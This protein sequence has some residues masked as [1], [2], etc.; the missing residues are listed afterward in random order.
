MATTYS[1]IHPIALGLSFAIIAGVATLLMGLLAHA[2]FN[3]KPL[4]S[5]LG[6]MYITYNPSLMNSA[7]GALIAA[8]N[9]LIGGYIAA[10]I[11]NLLCDY[12]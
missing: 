1:K 9:G 7:I 2:V 11:Y 12:I 4:V 8:V 3:G 5:M 10:W 6:S